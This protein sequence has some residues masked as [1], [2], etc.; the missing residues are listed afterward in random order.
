VLLSPLSWKAHFVVLILPVGYLLFQARASTGMRRLL[1]G[2]VLVVAFGL[3][4]LT[5][6]HV[7]G[8]AA[9]E[10]A[11]TQ[12]LVFLAGLLVFITS[13]VASLTRKFGKSPSV[14]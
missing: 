1:I 10:R 3:F 2:S 11:D 4:N 13:I 8:L 6:P 5:S 12:S 9:S 7:I 14:C